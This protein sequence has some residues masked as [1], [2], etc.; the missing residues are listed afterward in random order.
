MRACLILSPTRIHCSL[1]LLW[2][3]QMI[4]L[5]YFWVVNNYEMKFTKCI[6]E[7]VGR[8]NEIRVTNCEV[9]TLSGGERWF[10]SAVNAPNCNADVRRA[11]QKKEPQKPQHNPMWLASWV[12]VLDTGQTGFVS[13]NNVLIT[14]NVCVVPC[15]S[16]RFFPA[17]SS[18]A[19]FQRI[20]FS[21]Y[22]LIA[23]RRESE[24]EAGDKSWKQLWPN[25]LNTGDK[26]RLGF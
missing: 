6:V 22:W 20:A 25:P 23:Q 19:A 10:L 13:M 1:Y 21:V 15:H 24:G 18:P 14:L 4:K 17:H 8:I 7:V 16:N 9:Y 3:K 5:A 11:A 2:N 26:M 12:L